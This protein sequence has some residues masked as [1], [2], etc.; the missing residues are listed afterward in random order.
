MAFRLYANLNEDEVILE[1]NTLLYRTLECRVQRARARKGMEY[2]PC[3]PV[4]LIE[5][6]GFAKE[7]DSRITCRCVSCYP[8]ITDQ[9]CACAWQFTLEE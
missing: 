3:K 9:S 8:E 1:G 4:G 5:Y 2:H 7:I 6:A